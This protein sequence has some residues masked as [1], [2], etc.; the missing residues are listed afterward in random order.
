MTGSIIGAASGAIAP[1]V[2][3]ATATVP[4]DSPLERRVLFHCH[5][6]PASPPQ[7]PR[8]PATGT[9]P[10]HPEHLAALA[11]SLGFGRATALSPF[12]V[13]EGR[14][15][16]RVEP[17]QD[18]TAWLVDNSS[19]VSDRIIRFAS[20]DPSKPS[21]TERLVQLA[22][23]G[24]SG[25]KLHPV[26]CRFEINPDRDKEF[27]ASVEKLRIPMLIHTGVF[28]S[29]GA[30]PLDAYH[31]LKIDRLAWQFP[32][33]PLILAHGGGAAFCREVLGLL[34]MHD[35]CHLDLTHTLDPGYAWHIPRPEMEF[36]F[37]KIGMKKVIYGVDYPWYS[38]EDFHRDMN[39]LTLMGLRPED[40]NL[41]LGDNFIN[42]LKTA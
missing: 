4:G 24:F 33:I 14:C 41:I 37:S 28:G 32:E 40:F 16:S 8:D 18:G 13:P 5:T 38:R 6:F 19:K 23:R 39:Y 31:P 25:V 34:Q 7:F 29:G 1:S 10:G 35:H 22:A 20:L 11:S 27:Y 2:K 26:I 9:H 17:N 21:D 30:W 12:E 42:M 36:I 3:S 15:T